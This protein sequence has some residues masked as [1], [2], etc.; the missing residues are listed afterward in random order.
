MKSQTSKSKSQKSPKKKIERQN[1]TSSTSTTDSTTL[2]ITYPKNISLENFENENSKNKKNENSEN[3]NLKGI[4]L[5]YDFSS[6][7]KNSKNI[8]FQGLIFSKDLLMFSQKK[9]FK[10]SKRNVY[11]NLEDLAVI[12]KILYDKTI[13]HKNISFSLDPFDP[14]NPTGEFMRKVFYPDVYEKKKI[15][16]GTKLGEDMF[17]AD[18]L[19]KQMTIGFKPDKSKFE[20]PKELYNKGLRS[21]NYK[22]NLNVQE[23]KFSRVWVVIKKI[24]NIIKKNNLFCIDQIELGVDARQMEISNEGSL[25]DKIIQDKNDQ[26]YIFANKFSQLYENASLLYKCFYRLKEIAAALSIAK[27]IYEN[28]YPINYNLINQ[29]YQSTLIPNYNIKV[30]AIYH[31]EIKEKIEKIPVK[32]EDVAIKSLEKSGV[33]IN[34]KNIEL[35]KKKIKDEKIDLN[36]KR[37]TSIRNYIKGG[38][39]LWNTLINEGTEKNILNDSFSSNSTTDDESNINLFQVVNDNNI[40]VNLSNC[41]VKKFPFLKEEKCDICKKKLSIKEIQIDELYSKMYNGNFCN[42]HKPFKCPICNNLIKEDLISLNQKHYHKNCVKC[43]HCQKK[44]DGKILCCDKG[45]V[46]KECLDKINEKIKEDNQKKFIQNCPN[47]ELCDKKIT[48]GYIKFKDYLLHNDCFEKV[49]KMDIN[50]KKEYILGD[51]I[52]KI[53]KCI[54]CHKFI[55]E[56]QAFKNDKGYLH[57]EC[58]EKKSKK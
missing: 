44:F 22:N 9:N 10:E 41:D 4:N 33:E 50:E 20:I 52:Q 45:F 46:H 32:I 28:K 38:V 54:S 14:K 19:L 48:S 26:C 15:L 55:T 51:L 34:E 2:E 12:L 24:N 27:W 1:S 23:K 35:V 57:K 43:F 13:T 39:D 11:V 40:K 25:K 31:S 29:I 53:P 36:I 37:T 56:G 7:I 3:E 21:F 58:F 30:P 49:K 47:C 5:S 18:F 17:I 16:E 8:K 42:E 6:L